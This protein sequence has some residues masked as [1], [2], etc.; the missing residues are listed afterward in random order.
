MPKIPANLIEKSQ[1]QLFNEDCLDTMSRMKPDSIDLVVSSP[2]YDDLRSYKGYSFDFEKVA[3]GLW[4][5]IKSGG[6]VVWVVG[7]S[8]VNGSES[9][10][11]FRQALYFKEIGLRLHD[12]MLYAK[13]APVPLTHNRYEQQFEYMFVLSKGRPK[14]FNPLL[15]ESV[16][17][18][19]T[20]HMDHR[21]NGDTLSPASGKGKPCK[22]FRYRYNIWYYGKRNSE[23]SGHP[24]V[25]PKQLA[26]DQILSWSNHGDLVY[27]PFT[28][29]GTTGLAALELN[30]RF[31]G[32]EIS[33]E[34]CELAR[35]RIANIQR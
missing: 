30:R 16:S 34:Y 24:A 17:F 29:S 8:T 13:K 3:Q 33:A 26:V 23:S 2:P 28:G 15:E 5:V 10:T 22:A 27:D 12:T 31:I 19:K 25:F 21:R 6:V 35:Q 4:R 9:G 1:C 20:N 7:D 14:T 32:S 11:S 18:G